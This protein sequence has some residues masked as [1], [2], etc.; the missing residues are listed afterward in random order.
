MIFRVEENIFTEG[1]EN[2]LTDNI[3]YW[4]IVKKEVKLFYVSPE[5]TIRTNAWRL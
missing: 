2:R 5:N 4:Q 3:V 1:C